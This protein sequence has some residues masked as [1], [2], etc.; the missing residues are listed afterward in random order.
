[1][2]ENRRFFLLFALFYSSSEIYLNLRAKIRQGT[3]TV[4][5]KTGHR[6]DLLSTVISVARSS[7]TSYS[8]ACLLFCILLQ[9]SLGAD[10]LMGD[11]ELHGGRSRSWSRMSED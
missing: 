6:F 11:I 9:G 2:I 7:Y 3:C 1:M 5:P 4:V 8:F 10:G